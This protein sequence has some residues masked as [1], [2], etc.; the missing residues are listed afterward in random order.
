MMHAAASFVGLQTMDK[1]LCDPRSR[2]K[3]LASCSNT[4]SAGRFKSPEA[5]TGT[6]GPAA[7]MEIASS[8]RSAARSPFGPPKGSECARSSCQEGEDCAKMAPS[9][10][11]RRATSRRDSA[12]RPRKATMT[13]FFSGDTCLKAS[14]PPGS[15][16][17]QWRHPFRRRAKAASFS[18]VKR[19][20][21][22]I[23]DKTASMPA[24]SA[25]SARAFPSAGLL[26]PTTSPSSVVCAIY[27]GRPHAA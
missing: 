16:P 20:S 23:A 17:A 15:L 7:G 13:A 9:S 3:I 2:R 26:L 8:F 10:C 1:Y 4:S 19:T 22:D 12:M 18:F 25:F 11:T 5:V 24:S 14:T 21:P 6:V 27:P